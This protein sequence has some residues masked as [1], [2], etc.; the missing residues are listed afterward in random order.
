VALAPALEVELAL[1]VGDLGPWGEELPAAD[2][3]IHERIVG[4]R[5]VGPGHRGLRRCVPCAALCHVLGGHGRVSLSASLGCGCVGPPSSAVSR[6]REAGSPAGEAAVRAGVPP[7]A[8]ASGAGGFVPIQS[9]I[10]SAITVKPASSSSP[11][12]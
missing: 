7:A 5:A 10:R 11:S 4:A 12:E 8:A 9:V 2:E 1:V 3:R 6:G